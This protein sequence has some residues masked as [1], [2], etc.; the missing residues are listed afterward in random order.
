MPAANAQFQT[1][2]ARYS[3]SLHD[4][5]SLPEAVTQKQYFSGKKASADDWPGVKQERR[6]NKSA[7]I[8]RGPVYV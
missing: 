2:A 7:S 8:D 4:T 3:C 5:T 1:V 6:V